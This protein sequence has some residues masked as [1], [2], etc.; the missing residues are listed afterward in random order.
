MRLQRWIAQ[1]LLRTSAA[2]P[3]P[4]SFA[5]YRDRGILAAARRHAD[6]TWL[7]KMDIRDF[8]DSLSER[9]VYRVFRSL[10]YGA[11][12]SFQLARIC[13]RVR[14]ED[15][16]DV[17]WTD[18]VQGYCNSREGRLPQG[19]PTSPRPGQ[20]GCPAFGRAS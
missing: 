19:A 1:N 17:R 13:T 10:G 6:C 7:V 5:N 15:P 2:A 11:L 16:Q 12:L 8:F 18:G 4:A 14:E 9:R 20:L 3:H